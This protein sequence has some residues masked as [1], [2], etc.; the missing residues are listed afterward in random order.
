MSYNPQNPNGQASSANSSPVVVAS[1]QSAIPITAATLPLPAT[2]ATSTKQ[3]DGSQKTQVVDGSGNVIGATS[4]ALD[5]NIKSGNASSITANAGTNLN[6]SALALDASVTG[7]QVSQGSTTSGQ[8][9]DLTQGAVTTSA[10]SYT[11]SQTS[12]L[13]LTTAGAL[14]TDASATTQPVSGTVTITPSGTQTVSG[15]VTANAGT[16]LNT[17]ALALD[18]SVN[19]ILLAQNSTTSGQSGPLTQTATTTAAPT[20][21]TAKTNPLNTTTG[22]ALR[23]D[24]TTIAGT[25]PTTAGFID[26]K[27]ADGNIF[28]RQATASNLKAQVVAGDATGSAV[29]A[30]GYYQG[31]IAKTSLPSAATDG[32]LTGVMV[33]KF[34]RQ[35]VLP[36][37]MRDL[38]LPMTQLTLTSTTTETS[39]IAA[40][41][42]TFN[43]IISLVVI[44]TSATATQ[45]D[46]RDSTAGTIRLSLY[47]PAGDTR[48]ISLTT[49]LPQNAVNTAWTAKCGTSVASIIITGTYVTNK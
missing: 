7:L 3:S 14:R 20:Y 23:S 28:V 2:A 16:N 11:T 36:N 9:G 22:G 10:P 17:S 12:P 15:T 47:I 18:T 35:V 34:G 25:A 4:N 42:S 46:F 48:G 43:D 6:T 29:P 49:P 40:V 27:G 5:V 41:A 31:A 30:N 21:T 38:V 37:G 44:N 19:G 33:D 24:I 8:K 1:D 26:I 45:V 13:S 32:N 39:L